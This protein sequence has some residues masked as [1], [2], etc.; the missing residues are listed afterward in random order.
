MKDEDSLGGCEIDFS[1]E[2]YI[3]VEEDIL[4]QRYAQ[5]I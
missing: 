5:V 2:L 3:Y 1:T 4:V